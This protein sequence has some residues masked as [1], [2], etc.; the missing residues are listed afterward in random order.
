MTS[1]SKQAK[2]SFPYI[3][4][5]LEYWD[6]KA[7]EHRDK[8]SEDLHFGFWTDPAS[9][10]PSRSLPE[11]KRA[12]EALNDRVIRLA[13][14]Q[15]G[16]RV[17]DIGCGFG[18]AVHRMNQTLQNA[19]VVGLN[20]DARQIEVARAFCGSGI[21]GNQISFTVADAQNTG[22][23]AQHF[24][25]AVAIES[26][27][28]M[29]NRGKF[30]RE[31]FR[32][33]KP[34]GRLVTTEIA[35]VPAKI[36]PRLFDVVKHASL[37]SRYKTRVGPLGPPGTLWSYRRLARSVGFEIVAMEN[38]AGNVA[39]TY[40]SLKVVKRDEGGLPGSVYE[41]RL[42]DFG[43]RMIEKGAHKYLAICLR[44]PV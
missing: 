21:R 3:D 31:M 23:P 24:D 15:S 2:V 40:A 36:L 34:G 39:P 12:M 7:P 42:L 6:A 4:E 22:L 13:Q 11:F 20:I 37:L 5:M 14:V 9:A 33:L 17:I 29:P 1:N 19:T 32:I 18:G 26:I 43:T 41:P 38:W 8:F 44:K 35:L 25:S 10:S 28:H 27:L 30:F 16:S